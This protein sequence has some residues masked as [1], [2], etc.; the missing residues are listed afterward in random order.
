[1]RNR[2]LTLLALTLTLSACA[3]D[4]A[5]GEKGTDGTS[6][7]DGEDGDDGTSGT[8]GADG[9]DALCSDATP[10]EITGISG[11]ATDTLDAFYPSDTMTVESNAAGALSYTVAG[12]GLDYTWDGDS[13]TVTATTDEPS[14][15]V[16]VA[17]DGCTTATYE[18]SV[19]AEIGSSLVNI[20]H[21]YD[22]AP[23][24]D[25]TLSG[26]DLDNAILTGFNLATET[27]YIEIDSA[28][29]TF[30]LWVDGVVAA[31][32]PTIE[33]RADMAYSVVVYS[34]G[35][36][37][38][39]MVVV[40]DLSEVATADATRV[41]AT[42]VAD[43]VGQ[44]DVWETVLGAPLFTDLDFATTSAPL[45][46]V[47][48]VYTIGLDG[49][50]DGTADYGFQSV[51]LTGLEGVPLN[52]YAYLQSGTPFLF[53]SVPAIGAYLRV[54]PDPLPA[55]SSTT[56]G[57]STPAALITE[58]TYTTDA[59][60]ITD[61]CTVVDMTVNLDISHTYKGDVTATLYAPDGTAVDLHRNTGG[62]ADDIIGSY[63]SDGTGTL[64]AADD[65]NDF[66]LV[67]GGG[68]WTLEIYDS[69]YGDD[70]TL[71]AWDITLGCL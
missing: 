60:T 54:L 68:D 27:G 36:V 39:A 2:F 15:Q 26:D 71:N 56:T 17:T 31:T 30:D 62:S 20:I 1:M 22:G 43:G 61:A 51:D 65:L 21:L 8:D 58:Y 42:H 23:S 7:A 64:S 35:G 66:L 48:G 47:T 10:V 25:V 53:A 45:D 69:Y 3:E 44:V 11:M 4:G 67:N 19:D 70:G 49:D 50:D 63:A 32:L 38:N 12:Y 41:T 29:Y 40:D 52:V 9:A 57:S 16:L 34:D 46:V 18:F 55:A 5:D 37:P 13:F 24:V 14:S 6:G 33:P 59:I 28:P